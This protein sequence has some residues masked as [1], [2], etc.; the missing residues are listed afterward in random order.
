VTE[1][2]VRDLRSMPEYRRAFAFQDEIWGP[3]FTEGV[4]ASMQK[5]AQRV[6][7]VAAAAFDGEEMVGF[8]FGITGVE[9]GRPVHWSDILAV[10]ASHRDRG[11]GR[12]LKWHQRERAL[13]AGATT[14]LWT[15]DPLESRN[16]HLNLERLGATS[17]EY[18]EEMYGGSASPLHV[19][20]GTDRLVARWDLEDPRVRD[21]AAGAPLRRFGGPEDS[22][23]AFDVDTD[24]AGR[25]LPAP[26]MRAPERGS[27]Y[28]VPVPTD[29]QRLKAESPEVALAWRLATRE[30]LA[31]AVRGGWR[32]VALERARGALP[33]YRLIHEDD[34]LPP[35]SFDPSR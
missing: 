21:A 22:V 17:E 25:P 15:W 16:A 4:P 6:G 30:V 24:P 11:I 27:A 33:A 3:G 34:L 8:V 12:L 10:R 18:V 28:L 32:V 9:A 26:G 31:P 35:A 29:L 19:G 20:V 7:G 2:V 5:V 23:R 14:M 13:D 1:V